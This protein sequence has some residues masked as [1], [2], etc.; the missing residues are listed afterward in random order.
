VAP[1]YDV[2]NA[3]PEPLRLVQRFVNTV[4]HEH[5]REWLATPEELQQWLQEAGLSVEPVTA[6]D[7]RQAHELREAFRTLLI[8]NNTKAAIDEAATA[9]VNRVGSAGRLAAE[10]DDRGRVRL[11]PYS[12]GIDGALARLVAVAFTA[13]LD[14][15]WERLKACRNCRWAF[16]DYSNNRAATWCSMTLCG[17]RLKTRRYRQVKTGRQAPERRRGRSPKDQAKSQ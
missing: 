17:N 14:G 11:M 2:P 6:A 7:L 3:A 15:G 12:P 4:D 5:G 1:R 8:T 13:I 9:T 10:L 16:Y